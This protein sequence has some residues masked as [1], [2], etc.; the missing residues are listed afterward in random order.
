MARARDELLALA[1]E[2]SIGVR[3][4]MGWGG[5]SVGLTGLNTRTLTV[6]VRTRMEHHGG[7]DLPGH[8]RDALAGLFHDLLPCP[9]LRVIY[10]NE[11]DGIVEEERL[12]P[13]FT[14]RPWARRPGSPVVL[15]EPVIERRREENRR[16]FRRLW[17]RMEREEGKGNPS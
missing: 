10:S 2:M 3:K 6:T 7:R 16:K 12:L 5:L 4:P 17:K 13:F 9:T 8:V 14:G 15:V 11:A 1:N